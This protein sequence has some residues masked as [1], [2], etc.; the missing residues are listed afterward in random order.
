MFHLANTADIA[1]SLATESYI[2]TTAGPSRAKQSNADPDQVHVFVSEDQ[3]ANSSDLNV[4][5]VEKFPDAQSPAILT[6]TEVEI[7]KRDSDRLVMKE[8]VDH[9][10][11]EQLDKVHNGITSE[12]KI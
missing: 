6:P 7:K 12:T 9:N 8:T 11:V 3:K 10:P 1:T 5:S 2:Q 4:F